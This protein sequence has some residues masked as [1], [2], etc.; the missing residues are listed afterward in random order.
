M[1]SGN[2]FVLQPP[3]RQTLTASVTESL[4]EAIF[5]GLFRPGERVAEGQLA[6]RLQVSRAP[7]REALALL[8]QE[9]LVEP[10][11]GRDLCQPAVAR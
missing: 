1:T 6:T 3:S 8:E 5:A 10:H 11:A 4:R 7:I 9:G 2:T